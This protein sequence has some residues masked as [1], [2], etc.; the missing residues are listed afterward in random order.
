MV[1]TRHTTVLGKLAS[2]SFLT[3][4]LSLFSL[5]Y[6]QA[7]CDDVDGGNVT[8][9]N[10]DTEATIVVDGEADVLTFATTVDSEDFDFTY[11]V[12]DG[13]GMILGIPPADMTD[14]DGAGLG[15]CRV[16]GLSYTGDLTIAMG[17]DLFASDDLSTECSDLSNNHLKVFRVADGQATANT[18]YVSSGTSGMLGIYEVLADG[19]VLQSSAD[20]TA[21]DADGIHVDTDNNVLYQL[22]RTDNRID[23]YS[24][25]DDNDLT[26]IASSTSDF[27]N[28]R[29]IAV[30]GN[31]L[32]V[33][34][35]VTDANTFVVYNITP[36]SVTLDKTFNADIN[37]WGVH[38]NGN[39]L[40]AVSDNT[41]DIAVYDNFFNQ[42][43]GDID[44]SAIVTIEGLVRTHGITYDADADKMYLTDVGDGG[45]PNDGA[46][47]VV[48]NWTAA[49]ANGTVDA[50]EQIRVFGAASLLG[51]PVDIALDKSDNMV[52]VAERANGGGRILGFKNP[53]LSGGIAPAYKRLFAGAAAVF[54][55]GVEADFDECDF[56]AGGTVALPD[57][58]TNTTII[59]DGAPDVLSFTSAGAEG[60]SFTYVVTDGMG[61][62]LGVPPA[63]MTDFDGAGVGACRVYGLSYTGDL[64]VAMGDMLFDQDLSTECFD[65][66]SNSILVNRVAPSAPTAG[67]LV[68]SNTQSNIGAFAIL[69]DNAVIQDTL[70]VEA[71]DADGVFYDVA[72]NVVYQLNRTDGRIDVYSGVATGMLTLV[73]SSEDGM[74]EN[75]REITVRGNQLVA[76]DDVDGA[77]QFHIFDITANSV[78]FNKTY[79]T[80]INLWGI[81]ADGN[82]LFAVVD[83]SADIAVFDNFFGQ[84]DGATVEPTQTIT[85]EN[86]VRTHGIHYVAE[87]DMMFL[88]DVG[89]GSNPND[90]A[91]L[92]ITRWSTKIGDNMISASEQIRVSGGA[93]GLGNPVD[94]AY[95]D[96]NDRV[97]IAERANGGGRVLGYINPVA[98]GGIAPT[99][100]VLF[101]GASA[102]HLPG[103][104]AAFEACD[105]VEGGSVALP[106]GNTTTTIIVD[107]EDD[108]ISFTSTINPDGAGYDFTYVVTDG[109]G[110]V[111]GVPPGNMTEFNGAGVGA[112]RVYG[113]S[114]TG[115]LMVEA[116]DAL[117][118]GDDLSSEC[119]EL[120]SNF[121]TVDRVE[122]S[123]I[124]GLLFASSNTSGDIGVYSL[125]E[126]GAAISQTFDS[127]NEDADGI[128]Y[129][130]AN[131]VLYQLDRT[132]SVVN[133]YNNVQASIADGSALNLVA[134]STS[135]FTNG[136]EIAVS[137]GKLVVANDVTDANTL[138][139][140][141]VD[142]MSITLD[143]IFN[144]DINLWGI[145]ANGDQLIAVEDNSNNVAIYEDFFN[146]DA[147]DLEA[148]QS[149]SVTGIVRT[150]G[151]TYDAEEDYM[152]L[153]D[154]GS[155]GSAG[156]GALVTIS[157]WSDKIDD[158][159]LS[160]SEQIRVAGGTSFLGNPVDVAYDKANQMVYVAERARDGGRI[161]GFRKPAATG[162]IAPIY[163][164]LFAGASAVNIAA[165]QINLIACDDVDGG[166]VAF[167]DGNTQTTIIVDGEAD[168]ISFSTTADTDND[169]YDFTY[170]VTDGMGS[171]LGVPPGNMTD[172]DPAGLGACN[173]Y[174]LAYRGDLLVT[175]GTMLFEEDLSTDCWDLSDNA[176]TVDRIEPETVEANLFVASN[177]QA[178]IG[179]FDILESGAIIPGSFGISNMDSDGIFYDDDNDVLYVA[180]RSDNR[181]DIYNNVST[182]PTLVA[183]ST[184]DFTN[185][186]EI[187]VGNGKL[188]VA[189]DADDD[190]YF[191]VYDVTTS[192]I[193]LDKTINTDINLWGIHLDGDRLIAISDNTADV[194]IYDDFFANADGSTVS[195]SSI[196]TIENMVRT[197][198]LDY[199][200]ADD[201]LIL[202]DVGAGSNPNDGALV[203]VM[204]F[205]VAG[206]DGTVTMSE[207]ARAFGGAD[208]L[209]NPVDVAL[210]K[211]N[212]RIYVAE[213]A[214]GGG[215]LLGFLTPTAS[216]GIAPFYNRLYAGA[217]AVFIPEGPC[218]FLTGGTLTFDDGTTEKSIIVNDGVADELSFISDVDAAAGGYSQT[219]V[220]T[221]GMGMILGIPPANTVDFETSGVGNCRVYNVSY[222]GTL[223]LM[224]GDTLFQTE[225]SDGCGV[226]SSNSLLVTRTEN[227]AGNG[228]E[229]RTDNSAHSL[230][231]MYPSP[232]STR[233]TLIIESEVAVAGM[234]NIYDAAGTIVLREDADLAQGRNALNID[235]ANLETG[236]YFLQIPGANTLTKFVKAAR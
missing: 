46:L 61:M 104:E 103:N 73:A 87:K 148:S 98:T 190:N 67:F 113:L 168:V 158:D 126:N 124:N 225:I 120:S 151:L 107:D 48:P 69:E 221:D 100:N 169:D 23:V 201:M 142:G 139:V 164:R 56:V 86:M 149:V 161:L 230:T 101:A 218:D 224:Q 54:A 236:M 50:S 65:L 112:C 179:T 143:K 78:T 203:V 193:T 195:P 12:T 63:D 16:Y 36:A 3:L 226:I 130:E 106:D 184:S 206:A 51:N 227:F 1:K 217:S 219:F 57:G 28:G 89:A 159:T 77:N 198:G 166:T 177:N 6:L 182:T 71:E 187:A 171:V 174:G 83:N 19:S 157:D 220:V 33:A 121:I 147:G 64:T 118:G 155:A 208:F 22:N 233:L 213:R 102:I 35:D 115:D 95:D 216:G 211:Q 110:M 108:V 192:T 53:V 14:F 58:N 199:D 97:Y 163:N 229:F 234:V 204:D 13:M 135:D 15:V 215:R 172:F 27:T 165:A 93:S 49:S 116:G 30:T 10:G 81:Q 4:F 94:I 202:T 111:L 62:V 31:K 175:M 180:N 214:N 7:Q 128:F 136:R 232:V 34:N 85:I 133:V 134:T 191:V 40:F 212:E 119:F 5:S 231:E 170:V 44:A 52:W 18:V 109:M 222:T 39:Q 8:F 9:T 32:V 47:V 42:P 29:E 185:A 146:Q 183:S 105:F 145:H 26:L 80:S 205:A 156:D 167:A 92:R 196:V 90:G 38:A 209:G 186:R 197:H 59:V 66:S 72:N 11:V 178:Q 88:T 141:D 152:I 41:S 70:D 154:I 162:G 138:V 55:S 150:H 210:D 24:I 91:F 181:V 25:G 173:V 2:L 127:S 123:N 131:D 99:Y 200:S 114:Y 75:G 125:L 45:N 79:N 188:I 76:A 17:D 137:N 144:T 176:A 228:A 96:A 129:D 122:E 21:E 60:G 20:V 84:P 68:S 132:A 82:S 117:F 74:I 235:V 37:L 140:Y 160:T 43:A 194:G 207:Q 153:T 223:N 189:N